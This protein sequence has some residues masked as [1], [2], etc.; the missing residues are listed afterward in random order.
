[1]DP[2]GQRVNLIVGRVREDTRMMGHEAM[3][4]VVIRSVVREYASTQD[5]GTLQHVRIIDAAMGS[6]VR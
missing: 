2:N 6:A 3:E 1:M 4:F 5:R